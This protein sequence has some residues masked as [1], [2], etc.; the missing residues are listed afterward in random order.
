[1]TIRMEV[2][3]DATLYCGDC[4]EILPTLGKV[5]VV[6]TDPPYGMV[7]DNGKLRRMG[8]PVGYEWHDVEHAGA[9][10]MA[11]ILAL[12]V[13]TVLFGANAYA[14]KLPDHPGWIVWDKQA[15][16]FAQGSPAELAWSNCLTNLRMFRLNY[17]GF[18]TVNDPKFHAMQK[19]VA[20][21]EWVVG[22]R[23]IPAGI[24]LDPFAGSGTTGVACVN[25]G[26]RF[27]GIEIEPRYF[28]LACRRIEEAYRQPRL[29]LEPPPKPVQADMLGGNA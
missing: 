16:G 8:K 14:S 2:I 15:D 24:I 28:D 12:D 22:L 7:I 10:W 6:I 29:A 13:P 19:P 1:M 20:L 9:D 5:D 21:M 23:E 18:T 25:L 4:L 17:R 26:R 11:Q 3:G 27:I